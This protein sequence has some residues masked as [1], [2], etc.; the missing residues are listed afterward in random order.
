ME[1]RTARYSPT[2]QL[3]LGS[4]PTFVQSLDAIGEHTVC[5]RIGEPTCPE[6]PSSA[7][8]E[9]SNDQNITVQQT[10]NS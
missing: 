1:L 9:W 8:I 6:S 10:A 3:I 4:T 2:G 7:R 5:P